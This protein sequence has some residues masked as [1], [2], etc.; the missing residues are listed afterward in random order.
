MYLINQIIWLQSWMDV[1]IYYICIYT[2]TDTR[3]GSL[4]MEIL[5]SISAS[6]LF[7][8]LCKK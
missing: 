8:I 4:Q 2:H 6:V 7:K 1:N 3:E 5:E